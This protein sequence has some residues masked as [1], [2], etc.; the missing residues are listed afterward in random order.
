[1]AIDTYTELMAAA[2]QRTYLIQF[3]EEENLVA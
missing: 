2:L 3:A 1:M